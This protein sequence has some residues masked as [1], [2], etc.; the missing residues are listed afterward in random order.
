MKKTAVLAAL[1]AVLLSVPVFAAASAPWGTYQGYHVVRVVV[2]GKVV[3]SDVPAVNLNGRTMVP[4][5]AISD[6]LGV[7]VQWDDATKTAII[8]EGT[9]SVPLVKVFAD[10][11]L[12]S[13]LPEIQEN[14]DTL[15]QKVSDDLNLAAKP[16]LETHV[17]SS[18]AGYKTYLTAELGDSKDTQQLGDFSCGVASDDVGTVILASEDECGDYRLILAHEFSHRMLASTGVTFPAWFDEGLAQQEEI[19]AVYS[20]DNDPFANRLRGANLEAV[21][22]QSRAGTLQGFAKTNEQVLD[23]LDS[24]PAEQQGQVAVAFLLEHGD[25]GG[26]RQFIGSAVEDGVDAA[27]QAAYGLPMANVEQYLMFNL[28]NANSYHPKGVRVQLNLTGAGQVVAFSEGMTDSTG[29]SYKDAQVTV[30]L[31][32]GQNP[33]YSLAGGGGEWTLT[34][35]LE[36]Q[37]VIYIV[38]DSL[39]FHDKTVDWEAIVLTHGVGMYYWSNS[40]VHYTDGTAEDVPGTT[41]PDGS[42][43]VSVDSY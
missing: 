10:D 25:I 14:A 16:P 9:A 7:Q 15:Y 35:P 20:G 6:A 22:K 4:L 36:G 17:F 23:T 18:R 2:N 40:E 41:L 5:R 43:L 19:R 38:P 3:S 42:V 28:S 24:Y 11:T 30:D 1:L 37:A 12:Q 39:T 34:G 31:P 32:D 29:R 27:F 13:R 8:G 21:L 26:I 33:L